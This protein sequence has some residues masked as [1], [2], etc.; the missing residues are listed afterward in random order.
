MRVFWLQPAAW[1]GLAA[2]AVPILVHLVARQRTQRIPFPSLRFLRST[3]LSAARQWRFADWPLLLV[4]ML[5][6]AT[7]VAA[8]AAPVFVSGDRLRAWGK[9]TA[10]AVIVVTT[11]E[12]GDEVER[13]S[14]E[15]RRSAFAAQEFRAQSAP[16][17]DSIRDSVSWLARQPPAAR[18]LVVIGD[19]R[20]GALTAADF[21]VL[22]AHVG[23]RFLPVATGDP[24]RDVGR[25]A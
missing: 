7:T 15:E 10:R 13:L 12:T 11:P 21:D 17:A 14:S 19:L 2:L 20:M 24:L 22:P 8:F 16:V 5:I 25:G 18:E 9:R 1:W 6:L 23:I 3:R 4:R